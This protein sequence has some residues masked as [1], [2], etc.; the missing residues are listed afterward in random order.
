MC[1]GKWEKCWMF[2]AS[3]GLISANGVEYLVRINGIVSTEKYKQTRI[4]YEDT[5]VGM[6]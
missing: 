6:F 5:N 1:V 2:P 3:R 4:H